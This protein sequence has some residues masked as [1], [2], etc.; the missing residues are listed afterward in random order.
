[1]K[2]ILI[3]LHC[4]SNTGY[5][6]GPLERTFF[7][8][9]MALCEGDEAR[10]HFGYPTMK[11]GPSPTMPPHFSQYL[12]I[13]TASADPKDAVRVYQYILENQIDTVFGF[14][15]PVDRPMY[16]SLRRAGVTHFV[17]YWG[18]PMSSIKPWPVLLLKRLQVALLRS[19]PDHYVFE[20]R[21]MA[22]TAVFGRGIP[23]SKTSVVP[24]GVDT[25]HFSPPTADEGYLHKTFLIAA[26]RKVFFYSGHMEPRKG[27][28]TIMQA[29]NL[30]RAARKVADWQVVLLGNKGDEHLPYQK[31]LTSAAAQHVTFGGYR[32]DIHLLQREAYAAVIASTG[33]DSFP[34]SGVE[35]QASGLPLIV[36]DL[37]GLNESIQSGVT[38]FH[39]PTGDAQ[40]LA[41][42]MVKLLD[43]P[44]L[45]AKLSAAARAR[46]MQGYSLAV[47]QRELVAVM[48]RVIG[49]RGYVES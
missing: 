45:R 23:A 4:G 13:D 17:S 29:A 3:L 43:A 38:G 47:Q 27:V 14:D 39:F 28:A 49:K 6:I 37:P 41:D 12:I 26:D 25:D 44:S 8:M 46:I 33:W 18:A 21:G 40:A 22:D 42:V 9:A 34:R 31:M 15:Q 36:S 11:A 48:R 30:L 2:A 32:N 20:S 16:R 35:C 24:L 5:A 19:G 1:M 10:I 7:E